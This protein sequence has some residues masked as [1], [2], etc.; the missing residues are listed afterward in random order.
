VG[1]LTELLVHRGQG[2]GFPADLLDLLLNVQLF[3]PQ[4]PLLLQL[5]LMPLR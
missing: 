3:L 5:F 4:R 2:L 1:R